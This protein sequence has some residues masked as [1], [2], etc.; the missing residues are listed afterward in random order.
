[1]AGGF[2]TL[3]WAVN[4]EASLSLFLLVPID[5]VMYALGYAVMRASVVI[6]IAK[7]KANQSS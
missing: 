3:S 7:S 2:V 5:I 1:M 6:L 4:S